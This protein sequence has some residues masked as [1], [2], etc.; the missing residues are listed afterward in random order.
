MTASVSFSVVRRPRAA[1][2]L[3]RPPAPG[4]D[5]DPGRRSGTRASARAA[6]SHRPR[7]AAR[8]DRLPGRRSRPATS[9]GSRTVSAPWRWA[10]ACTSTTSRAASPRQVQRATVK[11]SRSG[12]RRTSRSPV[13]VPPPTPVAATTCG[14][15]TVV[16]L[17]LRLTRNGDAEALEAR[18]PPARHDRSRKP[19]TRR[20]R[21]QAALRSRTPARAR[22]GPNPAGGSGRAP[23]GH[24]RERHR[25]R[26][27]LD[28]QRARASGSCRTRPCAYALRGAARPRRPQCSER[29][30]ET[31][32]VNA[33]TLGAPLPLVAADV[34][35]CVVNR[36]GAPARRRRH[37]GR[38]QR[39]G[40]GH[41]QPWGPTSTARASRACARA[42]RP[43]PSA[44]SGCATPG[45]GKVGPASTATVAAGSRRRGRPGLRRLGRLPAVRHAAGVPAARDARDDRRRHAGRVRARAARPRTTACGG[46]CGAA[47]TGTPAPPSRTGS[48]QDAGAARARSAARP[49]RRV[50]ASRRRAVRR[51]SA[52]GEAIAPAPPF[53]DPTYPKIGGVTLAGAFCAQGS[54]A[55]LV[56]VLVGL[57]G[58]GRPRAADGGRLAALSGLAAR[59]GRRVGRHRRIALGSHVARR[60]SRRHR[61]AVALL[62]A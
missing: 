52:S 61:H 27:G 54:T 46:A 13:P 3:D 9:T 17:P 29:E 26:P 18:H 2:L 45:P 59:R 60:P 34:P 56:D 33:T 4:T 57:P 37:G 23:P 44:T 53:G 5:P 11:A 10:S 41:H 48:A 28:R 40:R 16:T 24:R 1:L 32:A 55:P 15:D 25:S 47:C 8:R 21:A 30:P 58:T 49:T 43:P 39:R 62:A 22:C 12:S 35:I 36:F 7:T 20:R 50:R 51:S 6:G 31:S 38:R 14:S 19:R 42:A